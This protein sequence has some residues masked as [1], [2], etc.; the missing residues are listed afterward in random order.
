M[1]YVSG[2]FCHSVLLRANI[3]V[4]CFM[5]RISS[6]VILLTFETIMIMIYYLQKNYQ[7]FFC[8]YCL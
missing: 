5:F 1:T 6:M 4:V 8:I 3:L 7:L 2:N